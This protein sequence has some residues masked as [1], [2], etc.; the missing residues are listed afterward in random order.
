MNDET[1]NSLA[2]QLRDQQDARDAASGKATFENDFIANGKA[3]APDELQKLWKLVQEYVD[4]YKAQRPKDAPDLRCL[5]KPPNFTCF[6]GFKYGAKFEGT[7]TLKD[8]R[9]RVSVGYNTSAHVMHAS[10]PEIER[11]ERRYQAYADDSGLWWRDQEGHY[12]NEAVK[13]RAMEAL[14][15]LVSGS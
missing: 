4:S 3:Q 9:L 5:G 6:G 12:T 7:P 1:E 15:D 11:L 8:Y 13:D 2:R 14:A 10:L